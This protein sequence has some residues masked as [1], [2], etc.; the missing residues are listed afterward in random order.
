MTQKRLPFKYKEEKKN[1][2]TV[3]YAGLL[4]ILELSRKIGIFKY[5]DNH[6]KIRAGDQG[7][8]DSQVV[9][10]VLLINILGGDSVSDIDHLESDE[11]LCAVLNHC[12]SRLLN[13]RKID[14]SS[15][16]RKGRGRFFPSDNAIHGYMDYFHDESE[17]EK[18]EVFLSQEKAFIPNPNRFMVCL[19]SF[20]RHMLLFSQKNHP[21]KCATIDVDGV[22]STS[23]KHTALYTYKNEKG[24]QPIFSNLPPDVCLRFLRMDSAGYNFDLMEYCNN[25]GIGFSLSAVLCK[26][27]KDGDKY[28]YIAI[29]SRIP[30]QGKLFDEDM[31]SE[32][33]KKKEY[34][35]DGVRYRLRVIVTNRRDMDGEELFHWH[36]KRCG[37]SEQVHDVMKNE[38]AGGRFPSFKFGVNAFWWVMMVIALNIMEIYKRLVLGGSWKIRRMKAIRFFLINLAGRVEERSRSIFIYLRG[39]DIFEKYRDK[40]EGLKWVPI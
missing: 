8:L 5:A 18:R 30:D 20:F 32:E 15:R 24:Y 26:A 27:L 19:L 2:K 21:V 28:R 29:R 23:S 38:L 10:S 37:Y 3:R 1:K 4:P 22:I 35:K 31:D 39:I 6:L 11:G 12:E 33:S 16:F 14:I 9:L 34:V 36:N 13:K 7:W 25:E 17:E 40:I